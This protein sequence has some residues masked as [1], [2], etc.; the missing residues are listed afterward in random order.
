MWVGGAEAPRNRWRKAHLY[1][2]DVDRRNSLFTEDSD[3]V[4]SLS[5][6]KDKRRGPVGRREATRHSRCAAN[7]RN[8]LLLLMLE[9]SRI[10]GALAVGKC[11]IVGGDQPDGNGGS[12]D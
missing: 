1:G 2:S 7:P 4:L 6:G 10:S 11:S 12:P 3:P 5:V 9:Q 8:T